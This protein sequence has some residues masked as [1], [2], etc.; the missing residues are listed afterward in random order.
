M[1]SFREKSR[2]VGLLLGILLVLVAS[3]QNA[4]G[5]YGSPSYGGSS[6]VPSPSSGGPPYTVTYYSTYITGGSVPTD[7]VQY[8]AGDPVTVKSQ[9]SLL[10][11][12]YTFG[13]WNTLSN[14]TGTTYH[15]GDQFQI[16]ANTILYAVWH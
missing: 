13:G 7:P 4:A 12:P 10:Y 16:N 2:S 6:M 1:D 8:A 5:G 3:C 15:A 11:S 9:G 14:G